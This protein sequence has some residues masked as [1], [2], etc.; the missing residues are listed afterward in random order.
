MI[1]SAVSLIL[2]AAT[3]SVVSCFPGLS[4]ET[5]R[6]ATAKEA[7]PGDKLIDWARDNGAEVYPR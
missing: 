7:G 4:H 6:G 1:I 5:N 3:P 2:L